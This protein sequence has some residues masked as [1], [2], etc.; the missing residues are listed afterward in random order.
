MY[1]TERKPK[2]EIGGGHGTRLYITFICELLKTIVHVAIAYQKIALLNA[3]M[4]SS[5][6]ISAKVQC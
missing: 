4:N 3:L 2:N 6:L 5:V 1:Y